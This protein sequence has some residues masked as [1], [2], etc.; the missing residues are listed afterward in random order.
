MS[1]QPTRPRPEQVG[2]YSRSRQL[3]IEWSDGHRSSYPWELLRWNC[4]CAVCAG[5]M[6]QPGVLKFVQRLTDDQTTLIDLHEVG[7][8]ALQPVWQDGHDTGIYSFDH[9]RRLCPCP[10]CRSKAPR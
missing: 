8:Y 5:E 2:V 9:L 4:P 6:G 7:Q 10:E 3:Q 1:E